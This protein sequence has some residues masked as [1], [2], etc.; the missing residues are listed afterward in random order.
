MNADVGA[1]LPPSLWA[2][3]APPAPETVALAG[4]ARCDVAVVGAGFT[5]LSAALHLAE[6]G[7]RV[8]VLEAAE[9]GF[10]ASGRNNGQVIPTLSRRDPDDIVDA[11]HITSATPPANTPPA[12]WIPPSAACP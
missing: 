8:T 1:A 12:N 10:G 2:D 7:T 4:A 6:A 11:V 9:I 5:G 3:T